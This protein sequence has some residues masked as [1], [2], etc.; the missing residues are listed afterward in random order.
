M[1][2][3]GERVGGGGVLS[4]RDIYICVKFVTAS[5]GLS[6]SVADV[7]ISVYKACRKMVSS[8]VDQLNGECCSCVAVRFL[9]LLATPKWT[10]C[11]NDERKFT[12]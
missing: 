11:S 12:D 2:S 7:D 6:S 8:A 4:H 1:G 10:A 3:V 9:P 5:L